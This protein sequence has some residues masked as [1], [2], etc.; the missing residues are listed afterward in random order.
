L[1][2]GVKSAWRS[3][4]E[5]AAR[6][7]GTA[8]IELEA[9]L[10]HLDPMD[11]AIVKAIELRGETTASVA[12]GGLLDRLEIESQDALKIAANAFC[13]RAL[14]RIADLLGY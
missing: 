4:F 10:R 12:T 7:V 8:Q 11:Q 5:P 14:D 2:P 9:L 6:T 3:D 13:K 1:T